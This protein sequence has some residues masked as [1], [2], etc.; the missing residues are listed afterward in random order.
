MCHR[1]TL[2]PLGSFKELANET[3]I[4]AYMYR[5][6]DVWDEIEREIIR[7]TEVTLNSTSPMEYWNLNQPN[8][9]ADLRLQYFD[10]IETSDIVGPYTNQPSFRICYD[11]PTFNVRDRDEMVQS[12]S[13]FP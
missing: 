3:S 6:L 2:V 10:N 9:F 11:I 1:T 4:E 7:I 5:L 8:N 13:I 12:F